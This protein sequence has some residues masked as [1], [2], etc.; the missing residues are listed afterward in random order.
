MESNSAPIRSGTFAAITT[1]S[2]VIQL[3]APFVTVSIYEPAEEIA[4]VSLKR[5]DAITAP[6]FG[7]V[8]QL[9]EAFGVVEVPINVSR[10]ANL[11]GLS[12]PALASGRCKD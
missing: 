2:F 9:K 4:M 3:A 12:T 1:V 8:S 5:S 6:L 11:N 10:V 7:N